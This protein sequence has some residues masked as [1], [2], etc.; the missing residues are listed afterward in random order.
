MLGNK[1]YPR[2]NVEVKAKQRPGQL[3]RFRVQQDNCFDTVT[4]ENT[5]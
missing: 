4:T 3:N 2:L 1:L 5:S